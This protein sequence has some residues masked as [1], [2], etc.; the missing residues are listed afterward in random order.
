MTLTHL[1]RLSNTQVSAWMLGLPELPDM[2]L[3]LSGHP[4]IGVLNDWIA[5]VL[6]ETSIGAFAMVV[7]GATGTHH[8]PHSSTAMDAGGADDMD[9]RQN[10]AQKGRWKAE[11]T[12]RAEKVGT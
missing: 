1:L 4:F 11:T 2:L 3:L 7:A 5:I 6:W 10:T 12:P 9:N 8:N